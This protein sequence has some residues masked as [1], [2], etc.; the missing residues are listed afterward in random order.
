MPTPR[1]DTETAH[2]QQPS[3]LP[4]LPQSP[5]LPPVTIKI[6]VVQP[7]LESPLDA[8]PLPIRHAKPRRVS[9]AALDNHVLPKHALK[10]E[11]QPLGGP[12]TRLIQPVGLPLD[13]Q[14]AQVLKRMPDEQVKR[15]RGPARPLQ[16]RAQH[17]AANLEAPVSR[18]HGQVAHDA[19]GLG[20]TARR[21]PRQHR[22]VEPVRG[23]VAAPCLNVPLALGE[24]G[25]APREH[26]R[27]PRVVLWPAQVLVQA[28]GVA[29]FERHERRCLAVERLVSRAHG[30]ARRY[31][32]ADW[33]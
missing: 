12:Q 26:V 22:V 21:R 33:Q 2:R 3:T 6:P 23:R 11:P 8:R 16:R 19:R 18:L 10:R 32:W 17:H 31:Q 1:A 13:A 4:T 29:C 9:L 25:K 30:L 27:P 28:G 24:R 20:L 15:L 7:R 14:V 5:P